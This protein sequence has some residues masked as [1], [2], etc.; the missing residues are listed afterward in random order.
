MRCQVRRA[1][2]GGGGV[3]STIIAMSDVMCTIRLPIRL[4]MAWTG[5]ARRRLVTS[6]MVMSFI[7]KHRVLMAIRMMVMRHATN[8]T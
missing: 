7:L 2:G 5:T 1:R 6:V 3:A 8:F 4:L